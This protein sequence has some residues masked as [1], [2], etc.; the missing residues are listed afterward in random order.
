[1]NNSLIKLVKKRPAEASGTKPNITQA[2]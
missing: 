2:K 1:M